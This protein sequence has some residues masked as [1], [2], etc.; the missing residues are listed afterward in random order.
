MTAPY[1]IA[2]Y[3]GF[4]VV[5]SYPGP[6]GNIDKLYTVPN[7]RLATPFPSYEQADAAA[8][9]AINKLYPPDLRYFAILAPTFGE[10]DG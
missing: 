5:E 6:S 8:K 1:Y 9:W 10:H 7:V 4:I 3:G 2:G